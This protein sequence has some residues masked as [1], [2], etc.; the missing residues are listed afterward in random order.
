MELRITIPFLC[1][2]LVINF[3]AVSFNAVNFTDNTY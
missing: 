3:V 1:C 2:T